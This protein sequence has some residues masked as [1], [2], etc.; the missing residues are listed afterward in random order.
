MLLVVWMFG[1]KGLM[2]VSSGCILILVSIR[3]VSVRFCCSVGVMIV[4][5]FSVDKVQFF[6]V[7]GDDGLIVFVGLVVVVVV[8]KLWWL[9]VEKVFCF[10]CYW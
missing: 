2:E 4:V 10:D 1:S 9:R 5:L 6:L 8:D 7:V 3:I